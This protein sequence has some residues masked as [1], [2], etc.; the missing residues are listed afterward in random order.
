MNEESYSDT[1]LTADTKYYYRVRAHNA[2]GDSRYSNWATAI[3]TT[4]LDS[5][6][7]Y[8]HLDE[9]GEDVTRVDAH[10]SND[11]TCND[12]EP[13]GVGK[14]YNRSLGIPSDPYDPENAYARIADNASLSVGDED[15]TFAAWLRLG[16]VSDSHG[17]MGKD[18]SGDRGYGLIYSLTQDRIGWHIGDSVDTIQREY[19][20]QLGSPSVDTW[21]FVVCWH[22]ATANEIGIQI[23]NGVADTAAAAVTPADNDAGFVLGRQ[24]DY[25]S[26]ATHYFAD[27]LI[28]GA[29]F[30]KKILSVEEK[31]RLYNGGAGM[32]YPFSDDAAPSLPALESDEFMVAII[33][34]S[35]RYMADDTDEL[36]NITTWIVAHDADGD[37]KIEI[38][39][40]VGDI[41]KDGSEVQFGRADVE[42]DILDAGSAKYLCG[43]G[44]HD[45]DG[46][47]PDADRTVTNFDSD[48][49]QGRFTGQGGWSGGF[50][51]DTDYDGNAYWLLT[52]GGNDYI[53]ITTEFSPRQGVL[54]WIDGLL[55]THSSRT[56]IL[57]THAWLTDAEVRMPPSHI[58][59][60]HNVGDIAAD[61]NDPTEMWDELVKLHSNL[62]IVTSGHWGRGWRVD[63]GDQGNPVTQI[64]YSH[65]GDGW[66][67]LIAI[68]P[69]DNRIDVYTYNPT[70]DVWDRIPNS[71]FSTTLY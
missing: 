19:A 28:D 18:A 54:T 47:V 61:C 51:D 1:E 69:T 34:D 37:K 9:E 70:Y 64:T 65:H 13:F 33:P 8:W 50:Y 3:P 32:M 55:T 57:V 2:L 45:Y 40:H 11:L 48:F 27:G 14:L 17:I 52:I 26:H 62:A 6:I 35:Q 67:R 53:F 31:T 7:S 24:G 39:I 58:Y 30:W 63:Y 44:N 68:R 46:G 5:L 71:E 4:L 41:V 29:G 22:D 66:L 15:F 10:G 42:F 36:E 43:G 16:D 23:N 21:Y 49:P 60:G 38:S 12:L 25:A 56:A 59:S 20:D